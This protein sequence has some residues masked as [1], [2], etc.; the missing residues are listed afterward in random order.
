MNKDQLYVQLVARADLRNKEF[1][2]SLD[3]LHAFR[4]IT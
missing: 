2:S 4:V 3:F 1:H